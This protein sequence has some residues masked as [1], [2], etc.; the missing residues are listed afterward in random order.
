MVGIIVCLLF[1]L[2]VLGPM[3]GYLLLPAYPIYR[4]GNLTARANTFFT[5]GLW[6]VG[7]LPI[8]S[9]LV[10]VAMS[11]VPRWQGP[12]GEPGLNFGYDTIPIGIGIVAVDL[13]HVMIWFL[14]FVGRRKK[15]SD[16]QA[17]AW[18]HRSAAAR[19]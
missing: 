15:G 4:P 11:L 17:V 12:G 16:S 14:L 7:L 13:T 5:V 19:K 1:T 18:L 8:V 2:A 3:L 10:A 9:I 6:I